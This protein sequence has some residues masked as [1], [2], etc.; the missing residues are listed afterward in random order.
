MSGCDFDPKSATFNSTCCT[1]EWDRCFSDTP[2]GANSTSTLRAYVRNSTY[3][4][5][6]GQTIQPGCTSDEDQDGVVD[7]IDQCPDT[8][9]VEKELAAVADGKMTLYT[10]G[11]NSGCAILNAEA[12]DS[13]FLDVVTSSSSITTAPGLEAVFAVDSTMVSAQASIIG[14]GF[15]AKS[16]ARISILDD[17]C[18]RKYD[19]TTQDGDELF[20][21]TMY[22]NDLSNSSFTGQI[23]ETTVPLFADID[24]NPA[25]I[26]QSPLWELEYPF[27]IGT[28]ACCIRLELISEDGGELVQLC[29]HH[30]FSREAS[31]K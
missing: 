1:I 31:A 5:S 7:G 25:L 27:H 6:L 30:F 17:T 24:F 2:P 16:I 28:V 4:N 29:L 12:W 10:T 22:L 26:T 11:P 3:T 23:P 18:T 13:I 19:D 14:P 21:I 15:D 8:T 20:T 9:T